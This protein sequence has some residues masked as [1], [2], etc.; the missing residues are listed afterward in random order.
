MSYS[1]ASADLHMAVSL[2]LKVDDWRV[3]EPRGISIWANAEP[4][5]VPKHLAT[6]S[7]L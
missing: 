4:L 6:A 1:Q 7:L 2:C 5:G 3:L